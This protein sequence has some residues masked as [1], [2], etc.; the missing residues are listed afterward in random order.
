MALGFTGC[1]PSEERSTP[2]SEISTVRTVGPDLRSGPAVEVMEKEIDLGAI[3]PEV[4]EIV[5]NILFYNNGS[6]P[7]QLCTF[8]T[9]T[10]T[11]KVQKTVKKCAELSKMPTKRTRAAFHHL[12]TSD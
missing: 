7:L 12:A 10:K 11:K 5:G 1:Q 9:P 6:E 2:Q 3:P 8:A 4:S